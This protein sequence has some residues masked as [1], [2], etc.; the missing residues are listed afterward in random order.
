MLSRNHKTNAEIGNLLKMVDFEL[1]VCFKGIMGRVDIEYSSQPLEE[2]STESF[3][4]FSLRFSSNTE[5]T[6]LPN[7]VPGGEVCSAASVIEWLENEGEKPAFEDMTDHQLLNIYAGLDLSN[8]GDCLQSSNKPSR[9]IWIHSDIYIRANA[10]H[11]E[12]I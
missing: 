6:S 1:H 9:T 8:D 5:L 4:R 12:P 10:N 11:S 3:A 7:R 2:A